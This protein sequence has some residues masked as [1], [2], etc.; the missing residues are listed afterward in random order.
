MLTILKIFNR[1]SIDYLGMLFQLPCPLLN[2]ME[3]GHDISG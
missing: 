3:R 2:K 1:M